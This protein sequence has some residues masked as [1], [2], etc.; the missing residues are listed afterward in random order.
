M[1][2]MERSSIQDSNSTLVAHYHDLQESEALKCSLF[3]FLHALVVSNFC[4]IYYVDWPDRL[5]QILLKAFMLISF[6]NIQF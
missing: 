2:D 6:L 1:D 3:Y 4:L 5:I